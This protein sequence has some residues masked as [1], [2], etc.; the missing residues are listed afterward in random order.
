MNLEK[1][2]LYSLIYEGRDSKDWKKAEVDWTKVYIN[3]EQLSDYTV[4]KEIKRKLGRQ[5][6]EGVAYLHSYGIIHN[7]LQPANILLD[8]SNNIKIAD[9]GVSWLYTTGT[10]DLITRDFIGTYCYMSYELLKNNVKGYPLPVYSTSAD[11]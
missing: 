6:L 3:N 5:L 1:G 11:V 7:D 10:T 2:S 8:D 4:N 9:F